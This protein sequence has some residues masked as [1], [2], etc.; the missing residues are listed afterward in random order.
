[1]K[2]VKVFGFNFD[3]CIFTIPF[4]LPSPLIFKSQLLKK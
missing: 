4:L 1:M 3:A 2:R